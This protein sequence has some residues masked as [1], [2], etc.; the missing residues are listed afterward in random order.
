MCAA[1]VHKC[2]CPRFE[3]FLMKSLR[4][5]NIV[6]LVGVCWEDSLLACCLEFVENGSLED[7]LRRTAGGTAYDPSKKK[8]KKEEVEMLLAESVYHGFDHDGKYDPTLLT[9]EDLTQLDENLAMTERFSAE[10]STGA[11]KWEAKLGPA[12]QPL[13]GDAQCWAM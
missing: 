11:S 7:W 2:V 3:C 1:F 12:D 6:K 5:P 9:A 4:H 8:K 10:C 13:E